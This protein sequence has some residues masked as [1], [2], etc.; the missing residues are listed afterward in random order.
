MI[1]SLSLERN[2]LVVFVKMESH[3]YRQVL[4]QTL[5][6]KGNFLCGGSCPWSSVCLPTTHLTTW[7]ISRDPLGDAGLSIPSPLGPRLAHICISHHLPGQCPTSS[8]C[9]L[10]KCYCS[11]SLPVH[12]AEDGE[13][14]T[15]VGRGTGPWRWADPESQ[16]CSL[17]LREL[18]QMDEHDWDSV[19]SSIKLG[20]NSCLTEML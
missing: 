5:P 11:A 3:L 17:W 20:Y 19:S 13:A 6:D 16:L 12:P 7:S 9:A 15:A 14:R 1:F 4:C 10:R 2:L 8:L 18:G